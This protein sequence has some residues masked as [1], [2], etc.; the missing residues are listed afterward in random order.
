LSGDI[1]ARELIGIAI[2]VEER[3]I[4]FYD[5]MARSTDDASAS[6]AFQHLADMERQHVRIFQE[7]LDN[8]GELVLSD[9]A[10]DNRPYLE[11]LVTSSVFTDDLATSEMATRVNSDLEAVELAIVAEKD[12]ILFYYQ[13]REMMDKPA[14]TTL[15]RVVEE[16]KQHLT[17]LTGIKQELARGKA[18]H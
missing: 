12:S 9:T 5:V 7:M 16:E 15:D 13:L 8:P 11:A 2:G 6:Q 10:R 14:H 18:D 3:G 4:A 1:K 17:Q